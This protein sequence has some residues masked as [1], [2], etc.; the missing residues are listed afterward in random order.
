MSNWNQQPGWNQQQQ[1]PASWSNPQGYQQPGYG[2]APRTMDASVDAGLRGYMLSIYNY[3][4]VGLLISAA[5]AYFVATA[6]VTGD[7]LQV[8]RGAG[9]AAFTPL[10][11]FL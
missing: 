10:G 5:V 1:P 3:M 11:Q 8:A 9:R 6:S 4:A 7:S 2:Y